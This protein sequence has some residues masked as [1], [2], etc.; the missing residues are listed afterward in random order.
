M[1]HQ[2][3]TGAHLWALLV[4]KGAECEAL[5][6]YLKSWLD[7]VEL[8][9][10]K[11]GTAPL[12]FTLHDDEHSF[13]VAKRMVELLPDETLGKLSDFELALLLSSA[14]L[15][16]IGMNPH[17][18]IVSRIRDFLLSGTRGDL[19][20]HEERELQRWLDEAHPGIQP[21]I[22]I[23]KPAAER[24]QQAEFLTAYFCR[25]RHND[26]SEKF[27]AEK[28]KEFKQHPYATWIQ[29]LTALCK[30]HHYGLPRL[31]DA[32]F[33]LRL[34]GSE[35]KLVNLRY[36]AA[37]LRVADVLEFDPERTPQVILAHRSPGPESKVY[38]YKDHQI[39]LLLE[40]GSWLIFLTARTGDAWTHRAVQDTADAVDFELE[41][42]ATIERKNGFLRG[43]RLEGED[44]Y[45]W[46]WPARLA[47]MIEPLPD[48]FVPIDGTF[49]PNSERILAL[50]AGTQ[51]YH[52][53]LAA[54]RELLQNAFDAVREQ[55]ALELVQ[56]PNPLDEGVREARSRLHRIA[57][58]IQEYNGELWLSCSDTGVGMTRRVIE[59]Y[60]LVSG[61]QSRPEV[62]ELR[63]ECALR[64]FKLERSGE[65]GIGVLSYFMLADKMVIETR[66][67]PDAELDQEN[68]GWRFETEGLDTV[69]ELRPQAGLNRGTLLKL[70]I[71]DDIKELILG[72]EFSD[73]IGGLIVKSP[74]V[75]ETQHPSLAKSIGPGWADKK[76]DLLER[77]LEETFPERLL[78]DD[79]SDSKARK[80][81][82]S[83]KR[84]WDEIRSEA[85]S[86]LDLFG[87]IEQVLPNDMGTFRIHLPYFKLDNGPSLLFFKI[88]EGKILP[89][90]KDQNWDEHE[91][92]LAMLP[93]PI[94]RQ[95]WRGFSSL[96]GGEDK[97]GSSQPS[98]SPNM[99]HATRA[100]RR[101]GYRSQLSLPAIVELDI[102]DN[103]SISVDRNSLVVADEAVMFEAVRFASLQLLE[104]FA[105]FQRPSPYTEAT[106]SML[107]ENKFEMARDLKKLAG[108]FWI[109]P[110]DQKQ[111]AFFW[112]PINFPAVL[113][114]D[115]VHPSDRLLN[116]SNSASSCKDEVRDF[117]RKRYVEPFTNLSPARIILSN[118]HRKLRLALTYE[119]NSADRI[120]GRLIAEFP[121]EWAHIAV[122]E[123]DDNT[124]Y[125][126][127]SFLIK[128]M[129]TNGWRE[130]LKL[131]PGVL[132]RRVLM[133][134]IAQTNSEIASAFIAYN[135]DECDH[136]DW[137]SL[138]AASLT[139]WTAVFKMAGFKS[140]EDFLLC[141]RVS[142]DDD[143]DFLL[144]LSIDGATKLKGR[145][146]PGGHT[147]L[148][149]PSDDW[150][151]NR[152]A[153]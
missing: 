45:R 152:K 109:F 102:V 21:P 67:S 125:N 51:L 61:S 17:R 153:E 36:L 55:I 25:H 89:L 53:P 127:D 150:W 48:T 81:A 22:L 11:G 113:N 29:D 16:D 9:L 77:V 62:L 107:S 54:V 57:L 10:A 64:G 37:I 26:W 133:D 106:I 139:S 104:R 138:R 4:E 66:S 135:C 99:P 130:L 47:S 14:Y 12:N 115:G 76:S 101:F 65:F 44:Y 59:R 31:M 118:L 98:F 116:R 141:W 40:K 3:W 56:D 80:E 90:A 86:R 8:L 92:Q 78:D 38:W 134:Q 32:A 30:S 120:D 60:L 70:R 58:S 105:K 87:P 97:V 49:R 63:R 28:A 1:A 15:H 136:E 18:E 84:Y 42:C 69:G 50:L 52:T 110:F 6:H 19:D 79:I 83:H 121:S 143:D 23:G 148:P 13:R 75:F 82:E 35:G 5:R 124:V 68:H 111:S 20:V 100:R 126:R 145:V 144:R 146:R 108:V 73:L 72:A 151:L 129:G 88:A 46:P 93:T 71:K 33:D 147:L 94:L 39:S 95:S 34:V 140:T 122:I 131:R 117:L 128:L 123:Y 103:A 96:Y 41:T 114:L 7:E 2:N 119:A 149:V 91:V 112:R 27:I 24:V 137:N 74:C 132:T 43:K 142:R 85:S